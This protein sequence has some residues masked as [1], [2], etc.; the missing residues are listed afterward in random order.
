[1]R[2]ETYNDT[3]N[4]RIYKDL[5][6]KPCKRDWVGKAVFLLQM[7]LTFDGRCNRCFEIYGW[8][9]SGYL[10][11]CALSA[12]A[13]KIFQKWTAFVFTES[14][15]PDQVMQRVYS[16]QLTVRAWSHELRKQC[17]RTVCYPL[18]HFSVG[19]F[20]GPPGKGDYLESFHPGSWQHKTGIAANRAGSVVI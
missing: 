12:C 6:G 14:W 3:L 8:K 9:F 20:A 2:K 10:I 15:S 13:N 18:S 7:L 4:I 17:A 19:T 5:Y 16:K 11:Q 1:M